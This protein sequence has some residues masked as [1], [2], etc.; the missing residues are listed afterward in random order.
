MGIIHCE[1]KIIYFV[2]FL[3]A[4]TLSW[5]PYPWK[6]WLTCA[7]ALPAI[8]LTHH[9]TFSLLFLE[10]Q[11]WLLFSSPPSFTLY[12]SLSFSL[13]HSHSVMALQEKVGWRREWW[14]GTVFNPFNLSFPFI[15][16]YA[17]CLT[18]C[19][20]GAETIYVKP[21]PFLALR[22]WQIRQSVWFEWYGDFTMTDILTGPW[23]SRIGRVD[24]K[25]KDVWWGR[26]KERDGQTNKGL[27]SGLGS[28]SLSL[29]SLRFCLCVLFRAPVAFPSWFHSK[30][31]DMSQTGQIHDYVCVSVC[32]CDWQPET[33][34]QS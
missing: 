15:L 25:G 21:I 34:L 7:K 9:C 24:G 28:L 14:W 1:G 8:N 16:V 30:V 3:S 27:L 23:K 33:A 11:T 31:L 29:F 22:G 12:F 4:P 6:M 5:G 17:P 26:V 32:V 20:P 2:L 10:W 13:F 18:F 19:R